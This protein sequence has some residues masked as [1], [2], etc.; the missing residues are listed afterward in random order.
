MSERIV[1]EVAQWFALALSLG[2]IAAAFAAATVRSLFAMCMYLAAAAAMAAGV[3]L[4]QG[5]SDAALGAA[6]ALG[7][8][9][10]LLILAALLLSARTA[11]PRRSGSPWLTIGAAAAAGV[12]VLWTVP[13]LRAVPVRIAMGA[14]AAPQISIAALIAPLIFV[15]AAACLALLG[16]GERGALERQSALSL[17]RDR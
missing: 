8:L 4:A 2:V 6:I 16:F 12:A 14:V 10:P 17:D 7:A 15:S 9:A 5:R 11:K 3:L 1:V 13:D